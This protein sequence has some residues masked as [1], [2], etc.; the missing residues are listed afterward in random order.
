MIEI[1]NFI[2]SF[3]KKKNL[4]TFKVFLKIYIF[5][6]KR[7]LQTALICL[8]KGH[9]VLPEYLCLGRRQM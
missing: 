2:R 7:G 8:F 9:R 1:S 3:I 4:Q 6:L 5:V